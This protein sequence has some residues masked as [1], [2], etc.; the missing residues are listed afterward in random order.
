MM[1]VFVWRQQ[2]EEQLPTGDVTV[3]MEFAADAP[4]PAPAAR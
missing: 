1:G 4:R 3:R 2:S